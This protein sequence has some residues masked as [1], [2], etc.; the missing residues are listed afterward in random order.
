MV[1]GAHKRAVGVFPNYRDAELALRELRDANF[2]MDRVSVITRE[3]DR[4][5][6]IAGADV[7]EDVGNKADE[8]ATTGAVAGGALGGLSG[9]LVGLG[10]LA[11]PGV[12]PIMLAGATAT[13]LATTA[14]GGIMGAAAGGLIGGLVGL[15]IPEERARAYNERV[16]RGDYLVI[17]EG[18]EDDIRR[19]EAVLNKRG[20]QDWDIFDATPAGREEITDND[21]YP[22]G[23][24]TPGVSRSSLARSKHAVGVFPNRRDAESALNELRNASFPLSQVSVV[25]SDA[26]R[27][28]ELVGVNLRNRVDNYAGLGIVDDRARIY[29]DRVNEGYYLVMVNGTE[30]EVRQAASILTHRGIQQFDIYDSSQITTDRNV[31]DRSTVGQS[32]DP[33]VIIIERDERL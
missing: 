4:H 24:D 2:P 5:D 22:I 21:V 9:L 7:R 27:D 28:R 19:A 23:Y 10:T 31:V 12:G 13:A 3:G 30:E 26:E 17:V 1:L 14:A 20:I 8:G 25:A 16:A 32:S 11:I 33:D 18:S 29:R 15:G 6:D